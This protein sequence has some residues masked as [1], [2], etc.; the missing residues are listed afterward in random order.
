M[1]GGDEYRKNESEGFDAGMNHFEANTRIL[2]SKIPGLKEALAPFQ[3]SAEM[4]IVATPAGPPS[5]VY[6]GVT[7][8][9]R[10]DPEKE[11]RALIASQVPAGAS[12]GLF[13]AFGLGYLPEQF[14][15][16]HPE[17]N[18]LIIEPDIGLFLKALAARDLA[19]VLDHPRTVFFLASEPAPVVRYLDSLDLTSV[20]IV[21]LRPLY[22]KDR[23]YY[24]RSDALIQS[25][26]RQ[27][28][29]N[30][31]TLKRFG[32]RWVR[33]LAQNMR[34]LCLAPGISRAENLFAGMPALV[35]AGGPSLETI[36]P[37]LVDLRERL[38]IIAVDTS[39]AALQRAGVDPDLTVI[40]DPQYWNTRHIDAVKKTESILVS[41]SSTHPRIFRRLGARVFFGSSV[42]PLGR[43]LE[44]LVGEKSWA[45]AGRW[46]PRPGIAPATWAAGRSTSPASIWVSRRGKPI[47]VERT[48]NRSFSAPAPGSVP[49]NTA[50]SPTCVRPNPSRCL[51]MPAASCLPTTVWPCTNSGSRPR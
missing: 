28:D 10:R 8:H 36:L 29:V 30:R 48:L 4:E 31:N 35:C 26:L 40:C 23:A 43:A 34:L 12:V 38:L 42:F 51:P 17:A 41:E 6:R 49:R 50:P 19:V 15:L 16:A 22:E 13:Y 20:Q 33:N 14:I 3:P 37:H 46:R 25:F 47:S 2:F 9:S 21:K 39:L 44:A 45:R 1:P 32:R 7:V 5:A 27:R 11:A 18:C 24:E